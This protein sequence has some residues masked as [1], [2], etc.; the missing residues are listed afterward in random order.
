[1]ID[2]KGGCTAWH[3]RFTTE[4]DAYRAFAAVVEDDGIASFAT[5]PPKVRH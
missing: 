1:V 3:E 5:A 4:L 2:Q